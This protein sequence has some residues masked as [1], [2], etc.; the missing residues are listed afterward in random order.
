MMVQYN[1]DWSNL[2]FASKKPLKE[3]RAIFIAAPREISTDRFTQ[4]VKEYLPKSHIVIGLAKE[5]Y[6]V[7]FESQEQFRT[8]KKDVIQDIVSKVN[9]SKSENKIYTLSYFQNE[10]DFILQKIPF[11]ETV[12]INGSWRQTFHTTP[13]YYTLVNKRIKYSLVS[14]FVDETEAHD[15]LDKVGFQSEMPKIGTQMT[16]NE[17]MQLADEA[18]KQSFDY[19]FQT[20]AVLGHKINHQAYEYITSSYNRVIPYQTYAMHHGNSR[21]IHFSAPQDNNHYDAI[22]AEMDLLVKVQAEH[23]NLKQTSLFINLLP[24]PSCARTIS[25]TDIAEIVYRYDYSEGYAVKLFEQ[26]GKIVRRL[27]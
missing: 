7:G 4:L 18:A 13:L 20:G 10:A 6:V 19:S 3:L 12:F 9:S 17:I 25:Q 2:A 23:I 21:E 26:C 11:R 1:F 5:E 16:I 24:C 27:V 8:L 14:P 15:Y 22:H